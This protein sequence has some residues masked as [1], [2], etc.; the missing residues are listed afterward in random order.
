MNKKKK[1][2]KREKRQK[3][4]IVAKLHHFIYAQASLVLCQGYLYEK[5][6]NQTKIPI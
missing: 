2:G 3:E 6:A 1:K 4:T 5:C